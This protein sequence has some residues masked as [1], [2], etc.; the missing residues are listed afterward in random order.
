M[1]SGTKCIS[2]VSL[3]NA[4]CTYIFREVALRTTSLGIAAKGVLDGFRGA[5]KKA[6]GNPGGKPAGVGL[7]AA[8]GLGVG[9]VDGNIPAARSRSSRE[10]GAPFDGGGWYDG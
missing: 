6:G 5:F 2:V 3:M 4:G 8:G 9:V 7:K 10:I 1:G